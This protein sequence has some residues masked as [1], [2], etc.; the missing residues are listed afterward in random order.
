MDLSIEFV[1]A[2]AAMIIG[3]LFA[4]SGV[5]LGISFK[6]E[7]LV[8][9]VSLAVALA[10]GAAIGATNAFFVVRLKMNAFIVTLAA[11]IWVRGLVV[12]LSGGRSAQDMPERCASSRSSASSP[13]R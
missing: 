9:P 10:V 2:L 11:Y 3:I 1:M 5:G 6:P 4:H 8:V 13:S 7:W 12:A